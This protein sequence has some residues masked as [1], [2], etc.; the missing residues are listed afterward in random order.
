VKFAFPIPRDH[1]RCRRL[2][3]LDKTVQRKIASPQIVIVRCRWA[4]GR[5]LSALEGAR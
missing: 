3:R 4:N 5:A 1:V 2:R